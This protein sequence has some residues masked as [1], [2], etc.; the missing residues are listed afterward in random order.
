MLLALQD[1]PPA[2]APAFG[3]QGQATE[4]LPAEE[5]AERPPPPS[6]EELIDGRRRPG[7]PQHDL[8]DPVN[9]YN[10]GAIRMPAPEAFPAEHVAVPD[11]WRL[12]DTLGI[13]RSRW[14]DPY[15]Q[16]MLK[17]DRPICL[18]TDEEQERRRA[19][20]IAA[21]RHAALPG[22]DRPRLVL[23]RQRRLRHG[24]RAP[25]LPDPGRRADHRPAGQ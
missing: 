11:R 25:L 15:N 3:A 12:V 4:P 23:R 5:P 6:E 8:P 7:V 9:Q 19:A 10:P 21:L 16:N 17:G 14:Y 20:G 24:D 13:V 22:P 18:P 1:A 2:E